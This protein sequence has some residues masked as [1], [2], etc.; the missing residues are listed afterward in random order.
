MATATRPRTTFICATCH[1]TTDDRLAVDYKPHRGAPIRICAMCD[2]V[3]I[4]YG[5][6]AGM[7]AIRD[8]VLDRERHMVQA[9]MLSV[10]APGGRRIDLTADDLRALRD[11]QAEG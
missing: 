6:D 1:L 8:L 4:G 5:E 2:N 10:L 7:A 9:G 11:L 3:L